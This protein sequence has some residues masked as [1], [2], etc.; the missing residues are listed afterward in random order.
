M[1]AGFVGAVLLLA[2]VAKIAGSSFDSSPFVGAL[3]RWLPPVELVTGALLVAGFWW[4]GI[5]AGG[6]LIV[7]TAFLVSRLARHSSEPCR[8]FGEVSG[9]PV[10]AVSV[11]RNAVLLAAAVVVVGRWDLGGWVARVIGV[12]LGVAL[13]AAERGVGRPPGTTVLRRAEDS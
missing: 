7:F 2:G 3:W 11:G 8:C 9:R 5:A 13:V 12:V 6:L 4:A 1:A 10:S